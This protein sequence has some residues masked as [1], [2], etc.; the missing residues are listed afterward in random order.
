MGLKGKQMA[1]RKKNSVLDD[2]ASMPWP[3]GLVL[4]IVAFLF[5]RKVGGQMFSPLAWLFLG[6]CWMA[7]AS[8]FFQRHRRKQLLDTQTSLDTLGQMSWREF[9]MLVGEAFRRRGWDVEETGLGGKD[10]GIDLIVR[11]QGR[12]ELVQCKQWR[13][14]Q[15][16][17]AKVREMW[18]LVDHHD[19][20]GVNI[21][22][23]GEFT[24]DAAK[25]A[26]GKSIEL[27]NGQRLLELVLE[28][29]AT[30]SSIPRRAT[31]DAVA[32]P[33]SSP[34]CPN[35][36]SAMLLR[37]NKGTGQSF[38]GCPEFPACRGTRHA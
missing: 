15:V 10:G 38:W 26:E 37:K 21:V 9:E 13:S 29:K 22:C 20:D 30:G 14:R 19:A 32:E 27:I 34:A 35:C 6:A 31:P 3:F 18:G 4:G 16:G 11:K 28:A 7:A 2:I 8:S 5:T 17:A 1:R 33:P 23:I 36:N 24:P 25:F 12:F